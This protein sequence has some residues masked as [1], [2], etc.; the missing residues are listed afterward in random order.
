MSVL[1]LLK[2]TTTKLFNSS[3]QIHEQIPKF[4]A[5]LVKFLGFQDKFVESY[6]TF[7]GKTLYKLTI[8][9]MF[10]EFYKLVC[11][12]PSIIPLRLSR[13]YRWGTVTKV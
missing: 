13:S 4:V 2:E 3:Q 12:Q 1:T 8:H 5:F 11:H 7:V 10:V 6:R 9:S